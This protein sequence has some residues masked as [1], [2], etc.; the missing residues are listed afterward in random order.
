MTKYK[1]SMY[2]FDS[3]WLTFPP[4]VSPNRSKIYIEEYAR[5]KAYTLKWE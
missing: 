1:K 3:E 5:R 2:N 4:H